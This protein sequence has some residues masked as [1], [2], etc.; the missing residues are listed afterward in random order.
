MVPPKRPLA[1]GI[2]VGYE[3]TYWTS[4]DE[5]ISRNFTRLGGE[6]ATRVV[7]SGLRKFFDHNIT[8]KAYNRAGMGPPSDDV[9]IK[10]HE[11]GEHFCFCI[12][13]HAFTVCLVC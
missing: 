2:I 12:S 1:N 4:E 3:V 10:T 6:N 8:V 11:D 13:I 9:I 7:I 5:A